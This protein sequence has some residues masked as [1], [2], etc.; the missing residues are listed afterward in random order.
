MSD[1]QTFDPEKIFINEFKFIKEQIDT[2]EDF[3]IGKIDEHHLENTLKLAFNLE[4]K[5]VKLIFQL[6]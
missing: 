4:E 6:K 2:P 3:I 1:N 5:L